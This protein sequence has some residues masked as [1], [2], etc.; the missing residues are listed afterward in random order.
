[1]T[2]IGGEDDALAR[3]ARLAPSAPHNAFPAPQA[4]GQ[5]APG[6]GLRLPALPAGAA[7]SGD[8]AADRPPWHRVQPAAGPPPLPGG[9]VTG[10]AGGPPAAAGPLRAARRRLDRLC[11]PDLRSDL[12]Q[13]TERQQELPDPD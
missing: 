8:H 2:A 13:G 4:P 11:V 7:P 6:Q 12:P 9:A 10:V 5:A 3:S 1:M